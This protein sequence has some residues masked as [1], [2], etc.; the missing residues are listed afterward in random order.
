MKRREFVKTTAAGLTAL[1]TAGTA[2]AKGKA[3]R[4]RIGVIGRTGRG[5]YG[6]GLDVVWN[7]IEQAQVVA[8][9]DENPQ[10]RADTAKKLNAPRTYA[11]YR[12]MLE[13][14][15]SRSRDTRCATATRASARWPATRFT[16]CIVSRGAS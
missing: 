15:E 7:D 1:A 8:V 6:H 11:D 12:K 5:N 10:G 16:R 3:P 9:A 4:Y 2:C 13:K 14:P